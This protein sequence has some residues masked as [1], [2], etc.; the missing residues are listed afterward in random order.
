MPISPERLQVF[1]AGHVTYPT[2][3]TRLIQHCL[4]SP[5]VFVNVKFIVGYTIPSA[6]YMI[7]HQ[8]RYITMSTAKILFFYMTQGTIFQID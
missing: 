3:S 6:N 2:F 1:N 8:G 4:N 5:V 7:V